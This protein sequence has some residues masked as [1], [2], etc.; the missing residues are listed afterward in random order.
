ME[1]CIFS[2]LPLS[3]ELLKAVEDM[4]FE[5]ASPIQALAIPPLLE[6]KDV[7]G[8]AQTGTGKTAAFGIPALEKVDVRQK[9]PQAIILCPTRELAIQVATE[10]TELA[11]RKRGVF[12][13]PIYGGQPIDRQIKALRR[14]VQV[15]V[16][17]PGRVMDHMKRG[18]ISLQ[19]I[20][21]AVLDEA[22]EMLDMGFRDDI[23][24]I[25]E[26][27]PEESQT[28]F[29]SATMRDEI[30][31]LA[32]RFLTDPEFLKVT[33]KVLT[34]PNI[35]QIYYEVR[36]FQKMDALCRVL[37]VYNPK[38]TIVFC[39]TKRGV[40]E[41]TANLQGH[42]YQADGL[43]GNLN[44]TQRDRV[45]NRFRKGNIEVLVATDVAAR[46][47]D[48]DDV[49]AVVNYDIPNDVEYYVH[50]IGRTGRAGRMGRAFTFVS[51]KEFWKLRDIKRYTKARIVQHQV[52]TIADVENAKSS[53]LLDEIRDNINKHELDRYLTIVND[54]IQNE[55]DG[56]LTTTEMAAALLKILM[57]RELGDAMP[58][59][60][61]SFGDTGAQAGMVRLFINVGRKSRIGA[62][63]IVGAIAGES[64]L[65]G[66]MIGAIDIYDRFTFVEV[67]E[68][69]AQE[70]LNVMNGNQI[71]GNK[72][73]VEPASRR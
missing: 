39:S 30:L 3:P 71:R 22:D 19:E 61:K 36:P 6:G 70:V 35:E 28:V 72:L 10:M 46:G 50:R 4:G 20:S 40:D 63:D 26:Q 47:I 38:L 68:D 73:F 49:E 44:Q 14:G 52:P 9:S 34:V 16:G 15:I 41:L 43:H 27:V 64:G 12:V 48:V 51:G 29:F 53:K 69:Y 7:I 66:K 65:P 8:Q 62:R 55:F 5:E 2:D 37:D 33:Q 67:P 25:L 54:F 1:R 31:S 45:M 56:D 59:E 17:T 21:M 13:L 60:K 42:G 18:T 23:E 32:K 57:H 24:F 58:E 11:K